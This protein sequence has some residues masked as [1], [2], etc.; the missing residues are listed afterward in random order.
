M[1][2]KITQDDEK[3]NQMFSLIIVWKFIWIFINFY[4]IRFK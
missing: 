1:L 2:L 3:T 4:I